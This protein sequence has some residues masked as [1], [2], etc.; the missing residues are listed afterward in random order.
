MS[1][2]SQVPQVYE[3]EDVTKSN[4]KKYLAGHTAKLKQYLSSKSWDDVLTS[5]RDQLNGQS[6][7]HLNGKPC[8]LL[9]N[10]G[11]NIVPDSVVNAVF[12]AS[13]GS[14]RCVDPNLSETFLTYLI[15]VSIQH[16]NQHFRFSRS[17]L[18]STDPKDIGSAISGS[19]V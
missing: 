6:V 3:C 12:D 2:P 8:L 9:H 18:W 16:A 17:W 15:T 1:V 10:L 7:P 4:I 11:G 19:E 5:D 14:G 13:P